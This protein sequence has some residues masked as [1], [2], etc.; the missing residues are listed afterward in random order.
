MREKTLP[1]RWVLRFEGYAITQF[2]RDA[3][4]WRF[5]LV[6]DPIPNFPPRHDRRIYVTSNLNFGR[7]IMAIAEEPAGYGPDVVSDDAVEVEVIPQNPGNPI[8]CQFAATGRRCES[9]DIQGCGPE[10]GNG[11][12][13]DR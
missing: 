4:G 9:V 13:G 6:H 5:V 7:A 11:N 12:E 10:Q 3:E 1:K 2:N 8:K